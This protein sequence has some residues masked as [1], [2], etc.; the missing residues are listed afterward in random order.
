[1]KKILGLDL[2]VASI[3]WAL[4]K[5][6]ENELEKSSIEHVGVR[7]N[8]I[9]VDE[10]TKFE[11]GK[12]IPTN[13]DRTLKRNMRRNLQRY[14]LRRN[15]LIEILL[16]NGFITNET[17]L[18]EHG[19][20]TTFE[21]YRLRAKAVTEKVTLEEFARVLLNINK[22]RG[23]KSSR[24]TK[25]IEEGSAIDGMNIARILYDKNLT[26]GQLTYDRLLNGKKIIPEFYISDL[27]DEFDRIWYFQNQFYPDILTD[28]LKE[29]LLNKN[30]KQSWTICQKTFN[31]EGLKRE[32]KGESQKIE[33]YKWRVQSLT[34]KMNLEELAIVFQKINGQIHSSSGYLGAISDRSKELYF[35]KQTIGQYLIQKL[36][37]NPNYSLKNTV[38][39]RQD[40]LDEFEKIWENQ[41]SYHPELT[42][43]LK[44][45]LEIPSYF[46]NVL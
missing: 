3:G 24:K 9:T 39:Y 42:K 5:Q 21:T 16:S 20:N 28:S 22:K 46:I 26:P 10:Q 36:N 37:Q 32:T 7:V 15:N 25:S 23:Y 45:K 2:G 27:R 11:T 13:A 43:E 38:F 29:E 12:S 44:K 17:I 1:M 18:S 33:N 30:E 6:G 35:K 34:E 8:P 41:S 19:N 4:V 40:Y 14:K 31:L